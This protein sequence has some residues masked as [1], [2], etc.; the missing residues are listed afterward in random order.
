ML[1][2][3]IIGDLIGS[4]KNLGEWNTAKASKMRFDEELNA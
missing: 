1:K 4:T 2:G 3:F